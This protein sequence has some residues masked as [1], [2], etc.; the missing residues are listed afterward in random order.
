MVVHL[1]GLM[2]DM[3]SIKK[4]A[5]DHNLYI[6]EDSAQ[7]FL[8]RDEKNRISGAC[9]DV[10]SWSFEY[11]KHI[12]TGDGGIVTTNNE[13]LAENMRKFASCGFKNLTAKNEN[14]PSLFK[15]NTVLKDEE[16][17]KKIE[18]MQ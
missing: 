9:S 7:C 6:L 4:I 12:T 16:F 2:A 13:K 14:Y 5:R 1:Y 3:T 8:G 11:T 15:Q 10:G 17:L 18:L